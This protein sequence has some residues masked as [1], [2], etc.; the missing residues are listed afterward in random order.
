MKTKNNITLKEVLK[1]LNWSTTLYLVLSPIAAIVILYYYSVHQLFQWQT[2]ALTFFMWLASGMAITV[3]YHRYFSHRSFKTN[4]F[5]EYLF[6]LFGSSALQ[7]SVIEWAFDHRN[8]H[9]FTDSEKDP[10]S[11]KRGFWHAHIIWLFF[12]RGTRLGTKPEIDYNKISDLWKDPFIRFQHKFYT[13]V[14]IF[15]AFIFPGLIALSWGDFWGGV[16]IAGIVRSVIVHHATFCINSVCHSLG[17][18]P[19]SLEESARDSWITALLTYGEGY[20]NFHHK[21]PG[22]YRNAIL[23]WQYDPSKWFIWTL[24]KLG[25]AWDLHRIPEERILQAKAEVLEQRIKLNQLTLK[26][27][28]IL[29]AKEQFEKAIHQMSEL[30]KQYKKSYDNAK[31]ILKEKQKE[32]INAYKNYERTVIQY[33]KQNKLNLQN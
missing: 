9:R 20:H 3:G 14:A 28:A 7:M 23:P 26:E 15:M 16:L 6:V 17:K 10:Y 19:Y 32:L 8:H 29:N 1:S 13:P 5:F 11:I 4:K 30:R 2:L 18:K 22:D 27:K 21:F 33:A 25:L 31:N 12:E 24:S